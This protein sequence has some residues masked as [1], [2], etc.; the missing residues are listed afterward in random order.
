MNRARSLLLP[1]LLL[2]VI[3][4]A[5]SGVALSQSKPFPMPDR[6]GDYFSNEAPVKG[7]VPKPLMAGS[8]WQVMASKL[9]CRSQAGTHFPVVRQFDSFDRIQA[10]VGRGGSDEVLLN[11]KDTQG[12]PWMRVRS[13]EGKAFQCYVRANRQYIMPYQDK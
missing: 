10:D 3:A 11:A 12:K 1:G 6:N 8:V 9:T 5:N 2:T 4:I 7:L 13:T